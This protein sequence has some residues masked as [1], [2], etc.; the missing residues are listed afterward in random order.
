[1]RSKAVIR[2][3][4]ARTLELSGLVAAYN[5]INRYSGNSFGRADLE[6][7]V[8]LAAITPTKTDCEK[9]AKIDQK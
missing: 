8:G 5:E 4:E 2:P 9:W 3:R 1:M 6:Y 7:A